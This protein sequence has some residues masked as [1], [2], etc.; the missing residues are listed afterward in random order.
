MS[1]FKRLSRNVEEKNRLR[2]NFIKLSSH[3]P[4]LTAIRNLCLPEVK[5]KNLLLATKI[6]KV[7]ILSR[8]HQLKNLRDLSQADQKFKLKKMKRKQKQ[9]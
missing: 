4:L 2:K 9:Q 1:K 6:S 7:K 5:K 8:F 3:I